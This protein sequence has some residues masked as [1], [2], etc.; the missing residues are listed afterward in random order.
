MKNKILSILL[1]FIMIMPSAVFAESSADDWELSASWDFAENINNG[2]TVNRMVSTV[3]GEGELHWDH[4]IYTARKYKKAKLEFDFRMQPFKTSERRLMVNFGEESAIGGANFSYTDFTSEGS[5]AHF[6]GE[7]SGDGFFAGGTAFVFAENTDYSIR[8]IV[9]EN[10]VELYAKTA[11]EE[12]YTFVGKRTG[13]NIGEGKIKI[14]SH[15]FGYIKNLKV[16]GVPEL[17][18]WLTCG[19]NGYIDAGGSIELEFSRAVDTSDVREKTEVIHDGIKIPF[20]V[21]AD[22]NICKIVPNDGFLPQRKYNVIVKAGL[23]SGDITL[24]QNAEF[25]VNTKPALT[26]AEDFDDNVMEDFTK[27]YASAEDGR[28]KIDN[29]GN[30]KTAAPLSEYITEF[31]YIQEN[32]DGSG[33]IMIYPRAGVNNFSYID[34][35]DT[36]LVHIVDEN[37]DG[38]SDSGMVF[39]GKTLYK[40]RM[41]VTKTLYKI[42]AA[43]DGG[44]FVKLA[45]NSINPG[46]GIMQ[47]TSGG[48]AYLDNLRIY[49]YDDSMQT[50][51]DEILARAGSN[52]DLCFASDMDAST[53]NTDNI[54][55]SDGTKEFGITITKKASDTFTVTLDEWLSYGAEYKLTVSEDVKSVFGTS[56]DEGYAV[57]VKTVTAPNVVSVENV[58]F[59][60]GDFSGSISAGMHSITLDAAYNLTDG[61]VNAVCAC[62]VYDEDETGSKKVIS[63]WRKINLSAQSPLE[64]LTFD[65]TVPTVS[66]PK[67]RIFIWDDIKSAAFTAE[68][69]TMGD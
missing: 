10:E 27:E 31:D 22:G 12:D 26:I 24:P 53:V 17:S 44:E 20:S 66:S 9:S 65:L 29:W 2:F 52:F 36:T 43:K 45:E 48:S 60:G 21:T 23:A 37:G 18:A 49:E 56:P 15:D 35:N 68:P 16:Y 67:I 42:Y 55:L 61:D 1:T 34:I 30:I 47:I 14:H 57:T 11:N 64:N 38:A 3:N 4:D 13:L 5:E 46:E 28:L 19:D 59:D 8:Y 58:K 63:K 62:V 40:F 69:I 51:P 50:V 54:K 6:V 41:I 39:S 32:T 7:G 33:R 25:T